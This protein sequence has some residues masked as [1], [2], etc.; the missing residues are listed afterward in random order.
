M[1]ELRK[2][3]LLN[4]WIVIA[5]E[6]APLRS[7]FRLAEVVEAAPCPFCPGH[8][9][10]TPTD[11]RRS[12][13]T[14]GQGWSLRVVPNRVPLLR[15]EGDLHRRQDGPLEAI[16]GIGAHEVI[17]ESPD[18]AADLGDLSE[19]QVEG[20][21]W[22][23][24]ERLRD[25]SQDIRLLTGLIFRNRGAAAGARLAHPHSQLIALPIVPPRV[26]AEL[27]GAAAYFQAQRR[28]GYCDLIQRELP[29][30]PRLVL[31]NERA[32][33]VAPWASRVPF[34]TLVLP[35]THGA[36]FESEPREV[37]AGVAA[38]LRR[39]VRR[40]MVA[41]ERPAWTLVLHTAP[42]RDPRVG[43]Y[44]WHLEIAPVFA[45]PGGF[46]S[47]SGCHVNPVPP[48]E[49]AAVLRKLGDV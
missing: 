32:V 43:H 24:S 47:G 31:Q 17:I 35:R 37:I 19:Q 14:S 34:E 13:D 2:D 42:L 49:A 48:E 27:T 8:E 7:E 18:H 28:C 44:H 1:S 20:V 4:R 41:L 9:H 30:G 5:P 46:E 40:L 45:Q 36:S 6:R 11:I 21:L 15:V 12:A 38:L 23:W 39:V 16:A 29:S 25:L 26:S 10:L 33:A 3:P 22:A